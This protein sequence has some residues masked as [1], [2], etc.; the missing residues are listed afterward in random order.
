MHM[1]QQVDLVA[2]QIYV[3][4]VAGAKRKEELLDK[5]ITCVISVVS[6]DDPVS[7]DKAFL[8]HLF[9]AND[10]HNTDIIAIA[11]QIHPLLQRAKQ[12]GGCVLVHCG[13]GI[14]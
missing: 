5:G 8:H 11:Q 13:A 14:S 7:I 10:D 3:S 2:P 6:K 12:N 9:I 1:I 4:G